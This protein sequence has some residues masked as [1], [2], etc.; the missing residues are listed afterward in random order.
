MSNNEHPIT[1]PPELVQ[2]LWSQCPAE[3]E[4]LLNQ[5]AT[6]MA[7]WGWEQRGA[8]NKAELQKEK[9]KE[10]EACCK[11]LFS[12]RWDLAA[13]ELHAARRP[14]PLSLKEQALEMLADVERFTEGDYHIIRIALQRLPG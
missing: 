11:W 1:P 3:S 14:K 7:R 8:A 13:N 5:F 9:D 12:N 6:L 2:Q 4:N 10:L